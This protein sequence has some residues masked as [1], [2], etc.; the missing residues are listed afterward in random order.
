MIP[1]LSLALTACTTS[2]GFNGEWIRGD[3]GKKSAMSDCQEV[4]QVQNY[5][6]KCIDGGWNAKTNYGE[7]WLVNTESKESK[8]GEAITKIWVLKRP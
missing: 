6:A 4:A 2:T 1:L 7:V 8:T 5:Q 3:W